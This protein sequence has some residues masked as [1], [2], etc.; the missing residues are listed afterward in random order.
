MLRNRGTFTTKDREAS[1]ESRKRRLRTQPFEFWGASLKRQLVLKEQN[2][3]CLCGIDS[4][5][6]KPIKLQVDHTD[7]NRGNNKRE[8]L[9]ALCPN[10]HSQT[11]TFCGK[12]INSG[13]IKVTDE[14]LI[15]ALKTQENIRKALMSVCLAPK[16][17]NYQRA[18]KLSALLEKED[19]EPF[20]VGEA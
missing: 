2:F 15:E 11:E 16:G 8:N 17:G 10:C 4:W 20:K 6:G 3:K 7:G 5:N 12:N 9:R 1:H 18:K 14:E 13:L 19:V